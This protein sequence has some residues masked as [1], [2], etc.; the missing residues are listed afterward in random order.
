[1]VDFRTVSGPLDRAQL[2]SVGELYGRADAKYRDL[3][4]LEH[5]FVRGPAGPALHAFA[6][7][8]RRPVGHCAVVPMP[9][10]SGDREFRCGKVEALYVDAGYRGSRGTEGPVVLELLQRLFAYADDAGVELLHAFVRPEVGRL[11]VGFDAVE[12]GESARV[13]VAT[14]AT[15]QSQRAQATV[16]ASGQAMLRALGGTAARLATSGDSAATLRALA[17]ADSDL[18]DVSPPADAWTIASDRSWCWYGE[19]P[20]LRVLE[21]AGASGSRALVQLPGS[22]GEALRIAAWRPRRSGLVPAVLSL[23]VAQRFARR[24]GA[25]TLRFQSWRAPW[26]QTDLERAAR[27][28]GFVRRPDFTTLY[29]RASSSLAGQQPFATPLLYLGF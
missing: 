27:L 10:R 23:L 8:G 28:L 25:A 16:L 18:V 7:D 29:V 9:A 12:I 2:E 15:L 24:S 5:L 1:M 3:R 14:T 21:L 11:F 19:S 6:C 4:F 17:A 26:D 22:Q 20:F 13:A